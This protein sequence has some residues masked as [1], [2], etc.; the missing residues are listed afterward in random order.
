[1][2]GSWRMLMTA[3]RRILIVDDDRQV[4]ESVRGRLEMDGYEVFAAQDGLEAQRLIRCR[5]P[6]VLVVERS[7]LETGSIDI[8]SVPQLYTPI[9]VLT[10]EAVDEERTFDMEPKVSDRVV[11]PVDP[12]EVL[13]RV[14]VALRR[15][16]NAAP[17]RTQEIRCADLVIDRRCHEV[18]VGGRPV[19]LTPT[20]FRLLEVLTEEPGRAFTRLEL[21]GQ[22]LGHDYRGLERNVDTHVKNLRKKIEPDPADP[23]YVETVYGV[24][25]RL[26]ER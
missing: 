20:E 17:K 26:A 22:V 3:K 7:W 6:D 18:S 1:M 19:D 15:A 12:C 2:E 5:Q 9:I 24:G 8:D 4:R 16:G 21:L 10:P 23:T 11:K 14:R 25:Y 13:S